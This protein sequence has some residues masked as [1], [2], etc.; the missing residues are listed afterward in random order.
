[1]GRSVRAYPDVICYDDGSHNTMLI[2]CSALFFLAIAFYAASV[3]ATLGAPKW[4]ADKATGNEFLVATRFLFI[5]YRVEAWY[6]G[7][8]LLMRSLMIALTPTFVPDEPHAQLIIFCAIFTFFIAMHMRLWPWKVPLLNVVEVVIMAMLLL[9]V[10]TASSKMGFNDPLLVTYI[11]V[12]YLGAQFVIV[13]A[14]IS[15][16]RSSS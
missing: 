13:M 16:V 1:M 7:V 3:F 12:A 8:F 11:A 4:S 5:R 6:W 10:T 14:G 2:F 15:L 9:T